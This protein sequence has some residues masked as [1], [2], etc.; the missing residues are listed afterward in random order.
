MDTR[1]HKVELRLILRTKGLGW[2]TATNT[3]PGPPTAHA[4]RSPRSNCH[5]EVT[6]GRKLRQSQTITIPD[7]HRAA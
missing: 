7:K 1:G 5:R 3:F 6:K 4:I 2:Q